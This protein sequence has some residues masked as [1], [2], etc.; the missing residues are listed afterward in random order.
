MDT[1]LSFSGQWASWSEW[2]TCS[3]TCYDDASEE[4]MTPRTPR[5]IRFRDCSKGEDYVCRVKDQDFKSETV[6]IVLV[7]EDL[8]KLDPKIFLVQSDQD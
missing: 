4:D 2:S 8:K 3:Q 7:V 1:Y 6:K 5:R